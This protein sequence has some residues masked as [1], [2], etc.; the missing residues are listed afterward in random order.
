MKHMLFAQQNDSYEIKNPFN[1]FELP[2][3]F[4]KTTGILQSMSFYMF[5]NFKS[6]V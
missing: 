5:L 1:I 2:Y 6:D 4:T 3:I